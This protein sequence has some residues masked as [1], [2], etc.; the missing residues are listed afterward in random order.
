VIGIG[1]AATHYGEDLIIDLVQPEMAEGLDDGPADPPGCGHS[2][3]G[4]VLEDDFPFADPD[5]A[6]RAVGQESDAQ[7]S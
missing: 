3:R 7:D 5:L 2:P 4:G 1:D 6:G